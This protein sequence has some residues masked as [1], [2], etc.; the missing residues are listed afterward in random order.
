MRAP[1]ALGG[2]LLAASLLAGCAV[3]STP[4]PVAPNALPA[5]M[6]LGVGGGPTPT[7]AQQAPDRSCDPTASLRPA[8][9]LPQPGRMPEGSTMAR[10]VER[11]RLIAGVDQTT[12]PF[13]FRDPFTGELAG[14]DIDMLHAVAAALFGDPNRIQFKAITSAERI[15]SLHQGKVDIV[16]RTMTVDCARLK[17]VAFSTVYYQAGQRVLVKSNSTVDSMDDLTGRKVCA[18]RGSTSLDNISTAPAR[19]T[20][21]SVDN[22]TD[23][24]VMMQQG[25]V[26]AV[27]TDDT[28]L[29]GMAAQDP[30]TK[31]VGPRF[32][33]EPYGIAMPKQDEDFVRFVNG[34]L[35]KVRVDGT[36]TASYQHWLG[37]RLGPVPAPPTA[38]Y[39]D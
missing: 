5:P 23:C 12:Y 34:V 28:I 33:D 9:P 27:S 3:P 22:W 21:V 32:T 16:A 19:P 10:I 1:G 30:Y 24:L 31:I 25:Q 18:A 39:R 14:F 37:T 36:W 7:T 17:Q 2:L 6:P 20:P 8:G 38:R 29:V 13:G 4:P 15:S 26:D 35:E 11:G